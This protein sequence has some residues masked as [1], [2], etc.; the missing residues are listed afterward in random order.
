M[1]AKK[2]FSISMLILLTSTLNGT[3]FAQEYNMTGELMIRN[4]SANETIYVEIHPASMVFNGID[5]LNTTHKRYDL[6]AVNKKLTQPF[7]YGFINGR[8][9]SDSGFWVA[10]GTEIKINHDN[11]AESI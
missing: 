8:N 4:S 9:V 2:R 11:D 10:P 5:V 7:Q 1:K 6:H 3:L